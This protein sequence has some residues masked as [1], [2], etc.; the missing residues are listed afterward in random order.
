MESESE[1][2]RES[3]RERERKRER[4]RRSF[5]IMLSMNV[6]IYNDLISKGILTYK[7]MF[8]KLTTPQIDNLNYMKQTHTCRTSLRRFV[9]FK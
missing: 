8:T 7:M 5:I 2:E 6:L 9:S 3:E 4:E 1:S